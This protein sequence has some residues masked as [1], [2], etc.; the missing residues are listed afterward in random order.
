M[1]ESSTLLYWPDLREKGFS[2][3][4]FMGKKHSSK[5]DDIIRSGVGETN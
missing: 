3:P 5:W 2:F 1:F 4:I